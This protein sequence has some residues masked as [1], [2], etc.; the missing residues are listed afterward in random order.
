MNCKCNMTSKPELSELIVGPC[1]KW[2]QGINEL[3]SSCRVIDHYTCRFSGCGKQDYGSSLFYTRNAK[4]ASCI[5]K[6]GKYIWCIFTVYCL[7]K[8]QF[9]TCLQGKV[10]SE[11]EQSGKPGFLWHYDL[12]NLQDIDNCIFT[13]HKFRIQNQVK[14]VLHNM[15]ILQHLFK[16]MT[17][18]EHAIQAR[19][20]H[21]QMSFT[22]W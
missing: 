8:M 13:H 7:V 20:D 14:L 9:I 1:R 21:T 17:Q 22:S 3:P 11:T 4:F 16:E 6:A 15:L 18:K 19:T 5:P 2:H 12:V 10:D